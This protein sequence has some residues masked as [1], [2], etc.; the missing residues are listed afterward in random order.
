VCGSE[1]QVSGYEFSEP[2]RVVRCADCGVY[3]LFPRKTEAAM[4]EV[5]RE[6]SY[7]EGGS[8]G[9]ADTGYA[10]QEAAL[11]ATFRRLL[12]NLS[13]RGLTGGDLLEIGCGY[14]YLLDEARPYFQR[15]AGTEFSATAAQRAGETGA[16]IFVGGAQQVPAGAKFDCIIATQVIEHVYQPLNFLK[17]LRT[18]A[19]PGGRIVVATPDIGGAL[20]KLMGRYWPSFKVPEHV[21]YFDFDTLRSVMEQAGLIDLR[22]LPHPHA[23]PL[24]LIASKFRLGVPSVVNH[25]KIWV[26]ATTVAIY[27]SVPRG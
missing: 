20:R 9:Y 16:E 27:G 10:G 7:F 18:L 6:L 26:P 13:K 4:Q 8:H 5:Y 21:V 23:F 14:G 25:A 17:Q 3:Y 11:R 15:R 2:Y 24:G 22:R 1:R 12:Q 19:K